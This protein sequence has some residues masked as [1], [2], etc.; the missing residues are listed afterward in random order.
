[1]VDNDNTFHQVGVFFA[2]FK[3]DLDKIIDAL[4]GA[5]YYVCKTLHGDMAIMA[6]GEYDIEDLIDLSECDEEDDEDDDNY[7]GGGNITP[8]HRDY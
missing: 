3:H 1:M 7:G 4:E 2:H 5:G 8:F 6:P